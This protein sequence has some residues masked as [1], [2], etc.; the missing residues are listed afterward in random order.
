MFDN[1]N[2]FSDPNLF[3]NLY[4]SAPNVANFDLRCTFYGEDVCVISGKELLEA[5]ATK[6]TVGIYC[7]EKCEFGVMAALE[8]EI[9]LKPDK[10]HNLYF[11][12]KQQR[13]VR[14]EI[15]DDDTI[16]T[17]EVRGISENKFSKFEML[18]L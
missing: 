10:M 8:A 4:D 2:D 3:I 14:I 11:K 9:N 12:E 1:G 16:D 13:I 18:I 17:I 5:N 7:R 15:P 6:I